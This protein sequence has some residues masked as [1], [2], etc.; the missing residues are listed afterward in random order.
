M[1]QD[2]SIWG[3][4]PPEDPSDPWFRPVWADGDD[5]MET[6]PGR[7][8][9]STPL[10][11]AAITGH[12]GNPSALLA[13]LAAAADALARLDAQAALLAPPLQAGLR[14]RLAYAEAAG[15][16]AAQGFVLH[17]VD[18]ALRE[19]ERFDRRDLYARATARPRQAFG[20]D[21][22]WLP[23]EEAITLA[24]HLARLLRR[25]DAADPLAS[26]E[27]AALAL[28]RLGDADPAFDDRRFAAW[29]N[30]Q[31]P[32]G[33]GD[34]ALPSLLRAARAAADWMT[35]GITDSPT[36][37]QALAVAHLVLQRTRL[38]RQLPLLV[39]AGWPA[40]GAP[41]YPHTL[42]RLRGD[43]AARLQPDPPPGGLPWAVVF[44]AYVTEAARTGLRTLAAL[45]EAAEAAL[46]LAAREDR[47]SKLPAVLDALLQSPA[48]TAASLARVLAITPQ[49][50][51]RLLE[52]LGGAG[53]VR[54]VTGRKS[55]RVFALGLA[56]R[57]P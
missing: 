57:S 27:T 19:A 2:D 4:D 13:A 11:G 51:L 28:A 7:P 39:W 12:T 3:D 32:S 34:Q 29:R 9:R 53:L 40:L 45:R 6:P 44:L 38:L 16:L 31:L 50:A 5:L 18:L 35:A 8:P 54:E 46:V 33:R 52:R 17:P 10:P 43:V 49:A 14:T 37:V 47:R 26:S 20:S 23:L 25:S 22:L 48:V 41:L 42:P 1:D 36:A 30:R 56:S 55:F 15:W 21:D 24:L